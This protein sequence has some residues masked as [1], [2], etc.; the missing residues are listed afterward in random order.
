VLTATK[1]DINIAFS[2]FSIKWF[3]GVVGYHV[4]LTISKVKP[5]FEPPEN[6]GTEGPEFK[7]RLNHHFLASLA[8]FLEVQTSSERKAWPSFCSKSM[9]RQ[10]PLRVLT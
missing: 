5:R 2:N 1:R 4:S 6:L 9:N 7:P 8:T 3:G 10:I